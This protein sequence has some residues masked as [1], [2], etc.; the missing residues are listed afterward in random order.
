MKDLALKTKRLLIQPMTNAEIEAL[1]AATDDDELRV[2]YGQMFSGCKK[3]PAN[4]IWYAPLSLIH[5]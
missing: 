5:I 4:R 2:A 3:D 1:M